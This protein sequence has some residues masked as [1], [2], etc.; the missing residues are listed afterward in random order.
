MEAELYQTATEMQLNKFVHF[1]GVRQDIYELLQISDI[2]ALPSFVEGLP[3]VLL[4]AGACEIPVVATSVG[5]VPEIV[6]E[7]V[8]G[9]TVP[10]GNSG[11]LA[12]RLIRLL[13]NPDLRRQMGKAGREVVENRFS[14]KIVGPQLEKLYYRLLAV[15]ERR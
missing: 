10:P 4:E 8:S 2:L 13:T 3:M 15:E 9:F 14:T 1:L 12:D 5:G 11:V 6:M 7:G